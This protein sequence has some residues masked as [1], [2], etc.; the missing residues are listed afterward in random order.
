MVY[1]DE[2]RAFAL[3]KGEIRRYGLEVGKEVAPD[4][5]QEIV[6]EILVKRGKARAMHL[7]QS[8]DRT[9]NQIRTKLMD[10]GY[11]Q[12]VIEQVIE[13]LKGYHYLDDFRYSSAYVRTRG[14]AK[15]IRQMQMELQSKGI[16]REVIRES[17]EEEP[18]DERAAIRQWIVKKNIDV[19]HA[20]QERIRRFY[21]FL[22]RKGF[23]YE[24]I[25][26]E[27]KLYT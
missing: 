21:Q 16:S 3:Y 17:L 1:I 12:E 6:Q 19:D 5:Y 20:Q 18:V 26:S 24:D 2:E 27:L 22:L 25:Q 4:D 9:E 15:S 23:K 11:P 7:L 10:G 14:K 8:M 13:Y